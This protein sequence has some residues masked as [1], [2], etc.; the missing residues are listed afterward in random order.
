MQTKVKQLNELKRSLQAIGL[1][2]LLMV[3]TMII[4][5]L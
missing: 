3:L 5:H 4:E 2:I 1:I